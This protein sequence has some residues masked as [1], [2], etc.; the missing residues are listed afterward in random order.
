MSN[1]LIRAEY[2][3]VLA[4]V[5]EFLGVPQDEVPAEIKRL[6]ELYGSA[7]FADGER[8]A[9]DRPTLEVPVIV[10]TPPPADDPGWSDMPT[11]VQRRGRRKRKSTE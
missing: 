9:H 7:C 3:L 2:E 11:P 10:P 5:S 4:A 1:A 6:L 8:Y